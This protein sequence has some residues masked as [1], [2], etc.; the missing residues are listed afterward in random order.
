MNK[1]FN[2]EIE[3]IFEINPFEIK[4]VKKSN[5]E[6]LY[7]KTSEWKKNWPILFPICGN[8]NGNLEHNGKTL[9]LER[10]GFFREIRNWKITEESKSR[11]VIEYMSNNDFYRIYPFKFKI[12]IELYLIENN[13]FLNI[14]VKNLEDETMFFSLGHHPGFKFFNKGN[15]KFDKSIL[16]SNKFE[17]GLI[18]NLNKDI[19]IKEFTHK[20][21]DFNNSKSY[22]TDNYYNEDII[23]NNGEI[24]FKIKT[25]DF[26]NLVLWRENNNCDFICIEHWNGLPD[27]KNRTSKEL[28]D[29]PAILNLEPNQ[30]KGF[31]L[32][33]EF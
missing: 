33:I 11:V 25:K 8:L 27:M 14:I 29:K 31:L 4:S 32:Q 23:L 18:V 13:F 16:F 9:K 12:I 20:S 5:V 1:I 30:E 28:K 21:L 22:I 26:K 7:Q 17:E 15:L 10:H 6:I 3:V 2:D 19:K 24:E